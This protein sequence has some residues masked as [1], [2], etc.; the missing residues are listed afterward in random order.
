M[1]VGKSIVK[2]YYTT[3][4][5]QNITKCTISRESEEFESGYEVI[6]AGVSSVHGEDQFSYGV[7]RKLTLARALEVLYPT[8]VGVNDST[9]SNNRDIRWTYWEIYRKMT[10]VHRWLPT[11]APSDRYELENFIPAFIKAWAKS[12]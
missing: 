3:N 11:S 6:A 4:D 5:G 12:F 8:G 10:K 2:W 9:R 1:K 7:G